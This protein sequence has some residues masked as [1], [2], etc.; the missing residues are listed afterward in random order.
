MKCIRVCSPKVFLSILLMLQSF[1]LGRGQEVPSIPPTT[2]DETC[3]AVV[4]DIFSEDRKELLCQT[5]SGMFY[6]IPSVNNRWIDEN[7]L[8]GELISGEVFMDIPF[9]TRVERET[10]TLVMTE[11]P[12]LLYYQ[13]P[14]RRLH[15]QLSRTTGDKTVLVVRVSASNS[16][17]SIDERDL[18]KSV[19]GGSNDFVNL[20]SQ[21]TAC[22]HG[23]LNFQKRTDMNGLTTNIRDGV[24]TIRVNMP[25]QVGSNTI[26]N[27]VSRTIEEE[28]GT[29][30]D[31]IA[32]H[33]M[34]CLPEGALSGVGY[35]IMNGV[36]SVYNNELCTSVSTQ[37]HEVGH[38]LN[39]G[40]S[41]M[42]SDEYGDQTG[43]MG[44][45]YKS[46]ETPKMCFNAA[47][48]F[49]LRWFDDK[50]VSYTPGQNSW[51]FNRSFTL[52]SV[53]DY[54]TTRS[55]VLVEILQPNI[56]LNYYIGFNAAKEFNSG[57]KQ[58]MNQVVVYEK[59][60]I[61]GNDSWRVADLS[62]GH[63][64]T[65]S[66]F[67]GVAG[68]TLTIDVLSINQSAGEA[69]VRLELN[70]VGPP[71]TRPPTKPPTRMPT[72]RP[73]PR[74]TRTTPSPT[75]GVGG[76]NPNSIDKPTAPANPSCKRSMEACETTD[77]CCFG[78]S[79]RRISSDSSSDGFTNV[80]RTVA[81]NSK[82]KLPRTQLYWWKRRLRGDASAEM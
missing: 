24:V 47:K 74:P 62:Q 82:D 18:S 63:R 67:N 57:V 44:Y 68:D 59:P 31:G 21:F 52:A 35:A 16:D 17:V 66:N 51:V 58:A 33:V 9:D 10:Q 3:L 41:G 15:R 14:S 76:R 6:I 70:R 27:E 28:F 60:W 30:V 81:K 11:P 42:G 71:P 23:K 73:T 26:V 43:V 1:R 69:Q 56:R 55:F 25:V 40:H 61:D 12:K 53:V 5:P 20:K 39:L 38:N 29:T 77:D 4:K 79:C 75:R 48:L 65:I 50:S 34:Y 8:S 37:M 78:Y 49:Q 54:P 7:M 19:F 80:C 32:S 22:S 13:N 36:L 45:S 46:S 64:H 72:P 2:L